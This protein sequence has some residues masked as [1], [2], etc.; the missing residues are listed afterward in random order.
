MLK[1]WL[2]AKSL[3]STFTALGLLQSKP[4]SAKGRVFSDKE[5][6][7][8]FCPTSF[9]ASWIFGAC[10]GAS[11]KKSCC[12]P[13][14]RAAPTASLDSVSIHGGLHRRSPSRNIVCP[15]ITSVEEGHANDINV[16]AC[17]VIHCTETRR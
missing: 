5:G 17:F 15:S 11:L 16:P 6:R 9:V 3:K 1:S 2:D 10:L 14:T 12:S 8:T 7:T 13:Y 4:Y